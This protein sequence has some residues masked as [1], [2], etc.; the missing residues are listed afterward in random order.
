MCRR[1]EFLTKTY[2]KEKK[3]TILDNCY[4]D[5]KNNLCFDEIQEIISR[6]GPYL[7]DVSLI[8]I[9]ES[10][11]KI[12]FVQ[13]GASRYSTTNFTT[14]DAL[15]ELSKT[16]FNISSLYIRFCCNKPTNLI[17]Q[18]LNSNKKLTKLEIEGDYSYFDNLINLNVLPES[19]E[20]ISFSFIYFESDILCP[21]GHNIKWDG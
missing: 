20:Q 13:F 15:E 5:N 4:V 3:L 9:C 1:W 11:K 7:Q 16:A 12:T 8:P 18:L 17:K 2:W 21:V 10:V 19:L 14:L 6:C